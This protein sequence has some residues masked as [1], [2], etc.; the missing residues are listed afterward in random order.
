MKDALRKLFQWL[1]S[2]SSPAGSVQCDICGQWGQPNFNYKGCD[3]KAFVHTSNSGTRY[4]HVEHIIRSMV[5]KKRAG[6]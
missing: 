1:T 5:A 3:G 2:V 6:R 4:V